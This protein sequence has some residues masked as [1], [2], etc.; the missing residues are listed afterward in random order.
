MVPTRLL[1]LLLSTAFSVFPAQGMDVQ[2]PQ[3]KIGEAVDLLIKGCG[4]EYVNELPSGED[5]K[6]TYKKFYQELQ[7]QIKNGLKIDEECGALTLMEMAAAGP[8]PDLA[9]LVLLNGA[10]PNK[11]I[12]YTIA[13]KNGRSEKVELTLIEFFERRL[14]QRSIDSP[15]NRAGDY[16]RTNAAATKALLTIA[17]EHPGESKK[18]W[19]TINTFPA[20]KKRLEFILDDEI[21]G[22]AVREE[23]AN[24][25]S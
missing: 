19:K 14:K 7:Q 8:L 6:N 13:D 2:M 21:A 22:S 4:F 11:K 23:I 9:A 25:K 15:L 18:L 10:N 12:I 5:V 1:P 20:L 24:Q 3:Q 16:D 17:M